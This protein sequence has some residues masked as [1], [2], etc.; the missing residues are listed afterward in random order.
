MFK[1]IILR[2]V[3]NGYPYFLYFW[4]KYIAVNIVKF[5]NFSLKSFLF[6]TEIG[7]VN[8]LF[9]AGGG[10]LAVPFLKSQGFE[11][12][13]AHKNAVAVIL[14]ITL[15]SAIMYFAKDIVSFKDA[16]IYI[17]TGVIGALIGTFII[18]KMSTKFLKIAFSGFMIYAG[19]RLLFK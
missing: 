4:A 6:G 5:K 2:I 1:E 3:F 12:K 11:Q 16:F 10:M 18:K 9:G 19:I 13:A 14:P 17:P 7:A 8:G 15:V